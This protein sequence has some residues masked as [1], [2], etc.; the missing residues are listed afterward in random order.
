MSLQPQPSSASLH[1]IHHPEEYQNP[2]LQESL[3]ALSDNE[4]PAA[5]QS[6][7]TSENPPLAFPQPQDHV[8]RQFDAGSLSTISKISTKLASILKPI[9]SRLPSTDLPELEK[10]LV[11]LFPSMIKFGKKP[12]YSKISAILSAPVIFLLTITLPVVTED[13]LSSRGSGGIHLDDDS[14]AVLRNMD[15]GDVLVDLNPES[16]SSE[17]QRWLTVTHLLFS[18]LFSSLVLAS[19]G[20]GPVSLL[21]P[22]FV[23]IGIVL[24]IL[25][26]LTT[27][28]YRRPPLF[29]MM[30]F[31]GFI[32][33]VL[34][35]YLI[36]NEVVGVL[37]T[38]GFALG[39]SDAILGLTVFAMVRPC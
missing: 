16:Y 14:E 34:W 17:W 3:D 12:I 31:V 15:D 35:I 5:N 13:A 33:A 27:S 20:V 1:T 19:L 2:H 4:N 25:L 37:Q 7:Q 38:I 24:S 18:S 30:C 22:I 32:I 10:V 6:L 28:A 36:A 39:I 9:A 26:V 23:S 8:E 29:W 21:I 11:T